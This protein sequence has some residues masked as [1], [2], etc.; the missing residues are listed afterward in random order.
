MRQSGRIY[1]R[2]YVHAG[3]RIGKL[4]RYTNLFRNNISQAFNGYTTAL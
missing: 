1:F 3:K 4:C 2:I